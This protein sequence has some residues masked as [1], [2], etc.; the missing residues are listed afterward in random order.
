MQ[1]AAA[2][3]QPPHGQVNTLPLHLNKLGFYSLRLSRASITI[4]RHAPPRRRAACPHGTSYLAVTYA[5][6]WCACAGIVQVC[7][8]GRASSFPSLFCFY[9][10]W[11]LADRARACHRKAPS[12]SL[13]S[14]HN[15]RRY[16]WSNNIMCLLQR[17]FHAH[18]FKCLA[19][20]L[21][22]FSVRFQ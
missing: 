10:A 20:C 21:R 5:V 12:S 8:R 2:A 18:S 1:P 3:V 19:A 6:R 16:G 4:S 14:P 11:Q 9:F 15:H 17:G 7:S 13:T 22:C